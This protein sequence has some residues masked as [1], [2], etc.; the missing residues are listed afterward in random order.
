MNGPLAQVV[1]LTCYGNAF[2]GGH[3]MPK[4]SPQNSTCQFCD[5]IK[6]VQLK[7]PLL[8]LGKVKEVLVA[9]TPDAW[10]ADL[11]KRDATTI[12]LTRAPQN[13]PQ[14]SDRMSAGF[15]GGSGTW[16]ME[17]LRSNGR[18][19]F[20]A[21]RWNVWNK[22][23]PERRIWRVTYGLIR[24]GRTIQYRGRTLSDVKRDFKLS[25]ETIHAFSEQKKCGEGFTKCFADALKALDD[26]AVDVGYH[27]DLAVPEQLTPEATSILKASMSA[28]VFGGMGSWN[29][30]G[31][32]G[33]TEKEYEKVSDSLFNI[34]NEAVE[35]ATTSSSG[36]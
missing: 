5:S 17:V 28:W 35:V 1:A 31:F 3:G 34:V 33:A 36:R 12:R 7:K 16:M 18:S 32:D 9:N 15:V 30:M 10:I 24:E 14:I 23:A 6:F 13:N 4:F 29:D 2:L 27:K 26:P 19:E 25:I 22:D 21:A 11:R 8:G 20:W